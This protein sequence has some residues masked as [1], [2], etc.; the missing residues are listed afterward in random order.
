M[1]SKVACH[2]IQTRQLPSKKKEK[3]KPSLSLDLSLSLSRP[4]SLD[5]STSLDL[6]LSTSTSTS[7]PP[8]DSPLVLKTMEPHRGI[9][10]PT[11]THTSGHFGQTRPQELNSSMSRLLD[12]STEVTPEPTARASF[13]TLTAA[14]APQHRRHLQSHSSLA[15]PNELALSVIRQRL[16]G[17]GPL[18]PQEKQPAHTHLHVPPEQDKHSAKPTNPST[19]SSALKPVPTQKL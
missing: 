7:P 10:K 15:N 9:P 12:L 18:H 19:V 13:S 17:H 11:A 5:L 14:Q 16:Q 2:Q 4:L 3:T 1:F 8:C 6:S